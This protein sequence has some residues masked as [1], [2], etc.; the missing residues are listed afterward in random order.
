MR[1]AFA[2]PVSQRS[3]IGRD[4]V[5]VSRALSE[6]GHAVTIIATEIEHP[7][8]I[9]SHAGSEILE[10]RNVS[11]EKLTNGFDVLIVSIGDNYSYHGGMFGLLG[12]LP[13][14][15]I[16]HDFYLYNLFSGW[17]WQGGA[18][19]D[20]ERGRLHDLQIAQTY[21]PHAAVD[22][23]A[24]RSGALPLADIAQRLPMT[25][26]MGARCD[27][28][29]AHSGFYVDRLR[30]SC[31]GPVRAAA[32]PVA[33]RGIAALQLRSSPRLTM[34]TVGV[35]NPNKCIDKAIAAIAAS[36]PLSGSLDYHL[37]GP[38][39]PLER[40]RLTALAAELGYD[41]LTIHGPVDEELLEHHLA[42][43]DIICCLRSPVLEGAS[44]SAIE[45]LLAGRPLIVA[46]AGFYSDLPDELV[47]K[48]P[49]DI[50]LTSLTSQLERLAQDEPLRRRTGAAACLWAQSH[51]NLP[52]YV[53]ALE[54]LMQDTISAYAVL[55][56]GRRFGQ[57]LQGLGIAALDPTVDRVAAVL[58]EIFPT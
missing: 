38:I 18:R 15:G 3:A 37:V 29:L 8:G 53:L 39:E 55:S 1:I 25:E 9:V 30:A 6:R 36:P 4:S 17:L 52:A 40:Q 44:G 2:T 31:P 46:D 32:M 58:G 50:E 56:V 47:F 5:D 27:G 24:A 11:S 43:A 45:G 48:V 34:V 42:A 54:G 33:G 21:G 57:R 35:M 12:R 16:F 26:W 19:P 28:A 51:F 13:T 23:M 20:D 41:A 14:V 7:A 22:A 10:W 49:A